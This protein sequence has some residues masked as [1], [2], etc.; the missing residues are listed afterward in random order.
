MKSVAI[1]GE[2]PK[3]SRGAIVQQFQTDP[4][5]MVFIGQ[6]DTAGTGIT[7]T[8]ADTC[9]Y[10]SV[11][12]N[13]ATYSQSLSRIHRIG[14]RNRCTYIHLVV[15]NSVDTDILRSLS[16]KEDLAKTVV[17]TWRDYFDGT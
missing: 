16:K 15:E 9:V 10:Y 3:E 6:I 13:Y 11:N 7:L 17:D 2:I 4:A 8:A 5:T 12:F 1:Y 14:Q